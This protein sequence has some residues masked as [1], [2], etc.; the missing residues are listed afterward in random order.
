MTED[1]KPT[2]RM[3]ASASR[4][5]AAGRRM[6]ASLLGFTLAATLLLAFGILYALLG[7]Q[8]YQDAATE[9]RRVVEGLTS[10]LTDQLSRALDAVDLVLLDISERTAEGLTWDN[11]RLSQRLRELPQVRALLVTDRQGRVT[12]SSVPGLVGT[13]LADREWLRDLTSGAMRMV[14]GAP[15]AGRFIGEPGRSVQETRRWT[16]PL[17][18]PVVSPG[19]GFGGTAVALLNPDYLT[20]IGERAARSFDVVVRF[21]DFDGRLLATSLGMADGVG[22]RHVDTWIFRDFLP[23]A[24]RGT[25]QGPDT[26]GI[27]AIASF[28]VTAS[29]PIVVEVA[30]P[31]SIAYAA[32]EGQ[33]RLLALGLALVAAVALAAILLLLNQAERLRRQGE[34][35]ADS[36]AAA[37]AGI[38]AKEEFVAAMSHEIR[39]PMNGLIGMADLLLDTRLDPLQRSYAETM[40]NSAEHL[41]VVL[42]DVLDLSRLEAGAMPRDEVAFAPEAEL[43]TILELFAPRAAERGVELVC[44]VAPGTPLRVTGDP[45]RFRQLLF[46]LVGNAVKFTPTG[47]IEVTLSAHPTGRGWQLFV[48]VEDTGLGIDPAAI[49]TLFQPFTQADTSIGRRFGGSGLGLAICRRLVEGMGG[50]IGAEARPGGGSIFRFAVGVGHAPAPAEPAALPLGGV[51]ILLADDFHRSRDLLAEALRAMQAAPVVVEDG[52]AALAALRRAAADGAPFAMALLDDEMPGSN[53]A[54]LARTIRADPALAGTRLVLLSARGAIARQVQEGGLADGLLLKPVL[55]AR[56]QRVLQAA[57]APP[58]AAP[59][60]PEGN[61]TSLALAPGAPGVGLNVLLVEDNPTNQVVARAML[62]RAG[63]VV[64]LAADGAEA[65]ECAAD[66]AFDLVLMDLQMPVMDGLE[67]TRRIRAADGPNR[68]TRIVGLTGAAG[69]EFEEKCLG[70]GMDGYV[71][72]PIT[73]GAMH[74]ILA[75][76]RRTPTL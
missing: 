67:A 16:V 72:K 52:R 39:T 3:D 63:A 76:L 2:D 1:T 50:S 62:E 65:V 31:A 30:Q 33:A 8:R 7:Y 53:G 55:P 22:R 70:A 5:V 9:S 29:G 58:A 60:N 34:R 25:H 28:G 14:V 75:E 20:A 23:R 24:E 66:E 19:D 35:L 59:A 38:R 40:Q 43:A 10:G 54:E 4:R 18:R 17:A 46:N 68:R 41:L 57:I 13:D 26:A 42:N 61:A 27:A 51:R 32:A 47:W 71:A 12:Y 11:A 21:H 74:G 36:E 48:A 49:P 64:R 44:A 69:P 6:P 73:R 45:A 56:L 37:R 15:E